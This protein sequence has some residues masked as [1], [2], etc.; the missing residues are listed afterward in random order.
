MST[1]KQLISTI[2]K[3]VELKQFFLMLNDPQLLQSV[4]SSLPSSPKT[5]H[6]GKNMFTSNP[7]L[8]NFESFKKLNLKLISL[9]HTDFF[10]FLNQLEKSNDKKL[11]RGMSSS[12]SNLIIMVGYKQHTFLKDQVTQLSPDLLI[13]QFYSGFSDYK[14]FYFLLNKLVNTNTKTI[15]YISNS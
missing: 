13:S 1:K 5:V 3:K 15:N 10:P 11:S 2:Q 7:L 9:E 14:K 6:V 8:S 12:A 4:C